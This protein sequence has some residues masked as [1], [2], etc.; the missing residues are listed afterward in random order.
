MAVALALIP[1]ITM[2]A[3]G[4]ALMVAPG[5]KPRTLGGALLTL[6]AIRKSFW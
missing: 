2:I 5:V 4:F 6:S 3:T 1:V